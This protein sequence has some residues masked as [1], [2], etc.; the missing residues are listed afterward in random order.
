MKKKI[1]GILIMSCF[2]LTG[3]FGKKNNLNAFLKKI[4][5][6]KGYYLTGTLEIVNNEDIYTYDVKSSYKDKNLYKV[7]LINKTND[8]EQ[9]V[10]KNNDGVYVITPS[11]N[12][13]FK[14]QSEWPYNN[15]Q[16]YLLQ[17]IVND[18]ESDKNRKVKIKNDETI[19]EVK[20][21]YI[22]NPKLKTQKIYLKNFV[23]TKVEVYD[24]DGNIKI[25]MK[26]KSVDFNPKF[27]KDY[28]EVTTNTNSKTTA[29]SKEL[30]DIIYP[31][32]MPNNTHLVSEDRVKTKNGERVI[33]SFSGEKP[34]TLIEETAT[35]NKELEVID[36]YGEPEMLINTIGALSDNGVTW[37]N[38]GVE[39]FAT[40]S[41]MNEVELLEVIKSMNN[42]PVSK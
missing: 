24:N 5:T 16:S 13:S 30:K 11:L 40:S 29:T 20:A 41:V 17:S 9:I 10:L 31:M 32:N 4:K 23:P 7:S 38:N 8:H 22:N 37:I 1:I 15:S 25:K 18:I 28:F 27:N 34:F 12:K 2:T 42:I 26:F 21:N 39:Y 35:V 33:L 3:C 6:A 14:F 36:T 19:I